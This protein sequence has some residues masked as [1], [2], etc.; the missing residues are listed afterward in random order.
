[1]KALAVHMLQFINVSQ[2]QDSNIGVRPQHCED[3]VPVLN[4]EN[5]ISITME[6]QETTHGKSHL[7]PSFPSDIPSAWDKPVACQPSR[8]VFP[9]PPNNGRTV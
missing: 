1:M 3:R 2:G 6:S 4:S 9:F 8:L 5:V 7:F